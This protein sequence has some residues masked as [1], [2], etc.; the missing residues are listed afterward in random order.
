MGSRA[1]KSFQLR[2]I[3][4]DLRLPP[5]STCRCSGSKLLVC[6]AS[7]SLASSGNGQGEALAFRGYMGII[8]LTVHVVC[9]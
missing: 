9:L 7:T 2:R 3:V 5:H 4:G 8:Y 6:L 1:Q